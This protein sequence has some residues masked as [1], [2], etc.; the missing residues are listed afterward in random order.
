MTMPVLDFLFDLIDHL[1]QVPAASS[2]VLLERWRDKPEGARM[3]MLAGEE[4]AGVE[5]E[6]AALELASVIETLAMEPAFRRHDELIAK[7]DL[8]EDERSELKELNVAIH[9]AKSRRG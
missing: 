6:G 2:A 1:Q 7:G 5:E 9:L 8:S 3:R 4:L